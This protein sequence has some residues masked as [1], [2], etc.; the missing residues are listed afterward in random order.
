MPNDNTLLEDIR[1]F[2][3]LAEGPVVEVSDIALTYPALEMKS[4]P[5]KAALANTI[6]IHL[7]EF[8]RDQGI[9]THYASRAGK[10][11]QAVY[12]TEQLPFDLVV[13]NLAASDLVS[14]FG[15]EPNYRFPEPLL[16]FF[17]RPDRLGK[18]PTRVS[19]SHLTAFDLVAPEEINVINDIAL[20]LNDLLTGVFFGIGVQL[21]DIRMEFGA[22]FDEEDGDPVI[23]LVS[24][25]NPDVMTLQDIRSGKALDSSLAFQG[26]GTGLEGYKEIARRFKLDSA[27]AALK[28]QM[29]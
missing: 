11:E 6:S 26:E 5:G 7:H 12:E 13:R 24:E 18:K 23:M 14:D 3:N 1:I 28:R 17:V 9:E 4:I 19:V 20:R 16:E 10:Q 2:K 25:L 8:V 15:L 21:V 29:N 22:R 27:A